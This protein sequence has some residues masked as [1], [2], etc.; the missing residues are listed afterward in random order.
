MESKLA[1][2][3]TLPSHIQVTRAKNIAKLRQ[4][5]PLLALLDSPAAGKESEAANVSHIGEGENGR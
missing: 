3:E 4:W 5:P 2:V 1:G